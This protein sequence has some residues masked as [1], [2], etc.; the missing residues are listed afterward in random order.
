MY[1]F[2]STKSNWWRPLSQLLSHHVPGRSHAVPRTT[3]RVRLQGHGHVCADS[4][5][6]HCRE[7]GEVNFTLPNEADV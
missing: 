6:N 7:G 4:A 2:S 3:G 1:F 5:G